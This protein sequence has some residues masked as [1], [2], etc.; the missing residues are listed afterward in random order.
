MQVKCSN[1]SNEILVGST[2]CPD[3]VVG[4][5]VFHWDV[6]SLVCPRCGQDNRYPDDSDTIKAP[7]D[8]VFEFPLTLTWA[9]KTYLLGNNDA[10]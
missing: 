3:G 7:F 1:C 4:C 6:S 9:D 5:L 2:P 10:E 8:S